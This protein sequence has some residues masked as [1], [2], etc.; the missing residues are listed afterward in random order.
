[1]SATSSLRCLPGLPLPSFVVRVTDRRRATSL[2]G[3]VRTHILSPS[4]ALSFSPCLVLG[5]LRA[6]SSPHPRAELGLLPTLGLRPGGPRG[7]RGAGLTCPASRERRE[8]R[9]SRPPRLRELRFGSPCVFLTR[10][11]RPLRPA[12]CPWS[13]RGGRHPRHPRHPAP[14]PQAGSPCGSRL[15]ARRCRPVP[16]EAVEAETFSCAFSKHGTGGR[17]RPGSLRPGLTCRSPAAHLLPVM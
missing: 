2:G 17:S 12:A 9:G 6:H 1:M 14:L 5:L 11:C 16:S 15:R 7:A 8:M 13:P 4:H 10:L 3:G